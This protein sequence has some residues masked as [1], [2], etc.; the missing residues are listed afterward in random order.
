MA[1]LH[2]ADEIAKDAV[3][4]GRLSTI[5]EQQQAP[6]RFWKAARHGL[7][8][9]RTQRGTVALQASVRSPPSGSFFCSRVSP[10]G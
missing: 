6:G 10:S 9:V 4:C 7:L 5:S 3:A 2:H 8:P 1:L